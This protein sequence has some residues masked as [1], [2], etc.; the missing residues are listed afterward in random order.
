MI[1]SLPLSKSWSLPPLNLERT[2]ISLAE[3]FGEKGELRWK[4]RCMPS[5]R[6]GTVFRSPPDPGIRNDRDRSLSRRRRPRTMVGCSGNW[7]VK[8]KGQGDF[9]WASS[10]GRCLPIEAATATAYSSRPTSE[11]V[12]RTDY[13][14]ILTAKQSRRLALCCVQGL[15]RFTLGKELRGRSLHPEEVYRAS[16]RT[17]LGP[18]VGNQTRSLNKA[19]LRPHPTG[20]R[21][22][23]SNAQELSTRPAAGAWE[24]R[25]AVCDNAAPRSVA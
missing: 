17:G 25:P 2:P 20:R 11:A 4:P 13:R 15:S 21:P 24:A 23:R 6:S 22:P 19:T 9:P 7:A 5:R 8:S 10:I 1:A 12:L 18:D 14:H 3:S 16:S